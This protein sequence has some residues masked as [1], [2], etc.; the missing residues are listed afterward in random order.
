ML[1]SILSLPFCG[2]SYRPCCPGRAGLAPFLSACLLLALAAGVLSPPAQADTRRV[3]LVIGNARYDTLPALKNPANEVEEVTTTLRRAGFDVIA[4][5]D[6]DRLALE[7]SIKRFF[8]SLNGA[9]VGLFYYSGHAVQLSGRNYVVPTDATLSTAYDVEIQTV[10]LEAILDQMRRT[11]KTQIVF[12]DA[13]RNNPF[14]AERYWVAEK[15]QPVEQRQGLADI[16]PGI[17]TLISFSTEPGNVSYDGEGPL[18]PFTRAFTSRALTP[19][20]EIRSLL[21]D[22]RRDV[23][24]ATGGRQVPWE[25]SS[26]TDAFY[27]ISRDVAPVVAPMQHVQLAA[28]STIRVGIPE[29]QTYQEA[30]LKV[31]FDLLP[32]QGQVLLDGAPVATAQAYPSS[33][34]GRIVYRSEGVAPGFVGILGYTVSNRFEQSSRGLV[35]L[36]VTDAAVAQAGARDA[37]PGPT[38]SAE[39]DDGVVME[40][41]AKRIAAHK[42]RVPIGVGPVPLALPAFDGGAGAS[43]PIVSVDAIPP[44]GVL[45]LD[46]KT[47]LAGARIGASN[48][49]RLTYEPQIGTQAQAYSVALGL[50]TVAGR[51]PLAA[52]IAVEPVLHAC[53]VLAGEP[54]DLAGVTAGVLPNEIDGPKAL[55][56]CN[57]ARR[58]HPQVTRFLYQLGRA[59]LASRELDAAWISFEESAALGHVRALYQLGYLYTVHAGRPIAW[60]KA[61]DYFR[62]GSE[63]GDPYS[64]YAYGRLRFYGRGVDADVPEGLQLML[65]AAEMG[66][67]YAMNEL[68]AIFLYG[69]NIAQDE[70]RG[71]AFYRAG[72]AR[73]DI[74]SFNNIGF[75]YLRGM[76]VPKDPRRA[77]EFFTAAAK[78]GHP[79]APYNIGRMYRDGIFVKRDVAAAAR[80]FEQAA[81]RGDSW[82]ASARGEL[83]LSRSTPRNRQIAAQ[84]FAL[85]VA[86][87]RTNGNAAARERLAQLPAEAKTAAARELARQLGRSFDA[88]G[89]DLDNTLV[90]LARDAWQKR[91]PRVDLF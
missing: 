21:T 32:E 55:A 68:G 39:S 60:D 57:E 64:M 61:S 80:W 52:K 38:R 46:G 89:G 74:Y 84:F 56:A 65:R 86:L 2:F 91:N 45:R 13:C 12:L 1:A 33:A 19:N 69:R 50:P 71:V 63:L 77:Y 15:L 43:E 5:V 67:T 42:A 7:E 81:E 34:L 40:R 70:A 29:P 53:D 17:G 44:K 37:A 72:V 22:V 6:Q 85:A 90:A 83:V 58:D 23:I 4:G 54:L 11:A 88:G 62:R 82:G 48:I 8:R 31:S 59:Q 26:L 28:G 9:D 79:A 76:G 30:D 75:A 16:R 27:F 10:D 18:S 66:H 47:V 51:A 3:A 36:T 24:K 49:A 73:Q 14:R 35:A 20:Q 87:D 78:G 41:F 25:N